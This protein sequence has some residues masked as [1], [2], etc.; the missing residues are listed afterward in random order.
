MSNIKAITKKQAA[1]DAKAQGLTQFTAVCTKH[2]EG[3]HQ[4]SSARCVAC[5][6]DNHQQWRATPKG[7][8]A[9]NAYSRQWSTSEVAQ[10]H[11]GE[12][13]GAAD[14]RKA[15]GGTMHGWYVVER[16]ALRQLYSE[17]PEGFAID[18]AIPKKAYGRIDGKRQRV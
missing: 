7:R 15:T 12:K 16:D 13:R 4:S 6:A 5:N 8:E 17:R 3:P 10:H 18:H 11:Q 14:W 1:A 9:H 2:G